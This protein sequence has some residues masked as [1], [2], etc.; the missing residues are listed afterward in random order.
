RPA[1]AGWRGVRPTARG[2]AV[3]SGMMEAAGRGR[4]PGRRVRMSEDAFLRAVA[5]QPAD[6]G[7]RLVYADW[8]EEQ[9]DADRAAFIRAQCELARLAPDDPRAEELALAAQD[10]LTARLGDWL[11][12]FK[13]FLGEPQFRRGFLEAAEVR[14]TDAAEFLRRA[15]EV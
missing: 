7:P 5:E 3:R 8:L 10:L 6:D 11:D 4:P 9:G 13:S 2:G 14:H 12:P 1:G 15:G